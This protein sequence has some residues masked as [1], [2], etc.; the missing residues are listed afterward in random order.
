MAPPNIVSSIPEVLKIPFTEP[1]E[2]GEPVAREAH[3]ECWVAPPNIVSSIPQVP[4]NPFTGIREADEPMTRRTHQQRRVAPSNIVSSILQ[5]QNIPFTG[6]PEEDERVVRP[7]CQDPESPSISPTGSDRVST[8]NE[9]PLPPSD[10]ST[11][12]NQGRSYCS[13]L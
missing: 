7:R 1:R 6:V 2:V 13:P 9:W 10:A 11:I 5:E 4:K 8:E 3:E 12:R